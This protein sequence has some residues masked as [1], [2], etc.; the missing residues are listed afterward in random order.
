MTGK[1]ITSIMYKKKNMC[2]YN[3]EPLPKGKLK[4][5][6]IFRKKQKKKRQ[7]SSNAAMDLFW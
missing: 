2:E 3:L 5:Y 4:T 1:L 7:N 6:A